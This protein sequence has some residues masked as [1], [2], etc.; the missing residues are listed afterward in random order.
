MCLRERKRQK[1]L[2]TERAAN[3]LASQV[4]D[5]NLVK[6]RYNQL[7]AE[8]EELQRNV[9]VADAELT[10]LRAE[11][12]KGQVPLFFLQPHG[13]HIQLDCSAVSSLGA[14]TQGF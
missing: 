3:L 8:N 11:R 4:Q 9:A 5:F 6:E 2:E 10:S 14:R 7:N 1:A 12:E 13:T